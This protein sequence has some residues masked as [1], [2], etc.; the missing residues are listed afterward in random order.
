MS[1]WEQVRL[2]EVI[3]LDV[4]AVPVTATTSYDIVG[5]LN[6]G[7]GLLFREPIAGDET[8]Y[9]TL[10]RIRPNQIVYSRLKAF[11]GA[12]TVAP[13]DLGEVYASQEFPT[14]TCGERMLPEYFRL[15]TT[16]KRLWE[17]LQALST[18]MGGRRER[19]KPADFLTMEVALPS[20]S[21]QCRIV[22]AVS[23]L[24]AQVE[25]LE[26][27]FAHVELVLDAMLTME[28]YGGA[29]WPRRAFSD[30]IDFREGP[31]IMARDFRDAGV[32]L[33]RLA[34]LTPGESILAKCN[35]LDPQ[36][37]D[38]KW[39]HFRVELGDVLLSTSA[40]LGRV[41]VVDAE[42]VGA[43]PYTGIIR[44]RPATD[45][46]EPSYIPW[47]LR[48]AD[49]A[50]QIADAGVGTTMA[51]FGPTHLRKMTIPLPPVETQLR[52]AETLRQV[53][54]NQLD[55]AS[56]LTNLRA[57]RSALLTSLLNQ[58]IG[59]P[60]SYDALLEEVS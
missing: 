1:E 60:E 33:I 59:I 34:G 41:A 14:F 43:I 21:E 27:E 10:N 39:S 50:S 52:I 6:R 49:F 36:K 24:D 18:G 23:A 9:K 58:E 8:S 54:A 12:I 42:G 20:L 57:F 5:V 22:D 48:S 53:H 11:E 32:P 45:L 26:V 15:L 44:M 4:D 25:A 55:I 47:L 30:V 51:H 17:Q 35:Y 2:D 3:A 13:N 56:E 28:T 37:V 29:E 46:V 40:A 38:A 19:V 31:G 7:R 16:T